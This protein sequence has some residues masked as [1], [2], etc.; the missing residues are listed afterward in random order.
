[1]PAKI[2]EMI[3]N[4]RYPE[5]LYKFPQAV[6]LYH[7][8]NNAAT[9]RNWYVKNTLKKLLINLPYPF[10]IYDTG[11]G[12][13]DILLPCAGKY[14][15]SFFTG[16]DRIQENIKL[17]KSFADKS[18]LTNCNFST[19]NIETY[20]PERPVDLITCIT[21]L[22]YCKNE[23]EVLKC[24]YKSLN[25]NGILL[26]YVPVNYKRIFRWFDTLRSVK[27]KTVDY[28]STMGI[29]HHFTDLEIK[30]KVKA[31]GFSISESITTYKT[32]GKISFELYSSFL[33]IVKI[34][35]FFTG[36]LLFP[37][38][39]IIY[40]LILILMFLDL[41]QRNNDGNGLLLIAKKPDIT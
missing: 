24:F 6:K 16:I 13:G 19:G 8:I 41:F 18:L 26:L 28:D 32:C 21:V 20:I 22:Q 38:F 4:H 27:G 7:F 39:L 9:L 37:I 23:T 40:P 10:H 12:S 25:P 36:F 3:N 1:M 34:L 31:A 2:T 17:C 5:I 11:C 33:T 35:P 30:D 15:T 29:Y 14:K